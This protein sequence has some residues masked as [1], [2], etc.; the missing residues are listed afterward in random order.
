MTLCDL[1]FNRILKLMG[2]KKGKGK[3]KG[4]KGK[5]PEEPDEST[6]KLQR[7]YWKKCTELEAPYSKIMREK[8]AEAED[9][10]EDI[11]KIHLWEELGWQGVKALMDALI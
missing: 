1:K 11:T 2:G 10:D 8:F 5:V 6:E 4:K 3:G 9:E 7:L